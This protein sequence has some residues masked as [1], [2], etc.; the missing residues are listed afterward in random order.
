MSLLRQALKSRLGTSSRSPADSPPP[1]KS[2]AR[3]IRSVASVKT[4]AAS[5]AS[6]YT[7]S[8]GSGG[9]P[10]QA[11]RRRAPRSE[12]GR[13]AFTSRDPELALVDG[14]EMCV[15][16]GRV[17]GVTCVRT[18]EEGGRARVSLLVNHFAEIGERGVI[19]Y[20]GSESPRS[21]SDMVLICG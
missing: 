20:G 21:S 19:F 7:F 15:E 11:K 17:S 8:P 5:L 3:S 18:L 9:G 14:V 1:K 6:F 13:P 4:L 12:L 16:G 10:R 2:Y